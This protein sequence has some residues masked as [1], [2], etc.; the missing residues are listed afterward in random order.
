MGLD[1][2][3]VNDW[4]PTSKLM[5]GNNTVNVVKTFEAWTSFSSLNDYLKKGDIVDDEMVNYFTNVMPP[6]FHTS[7]IIQMGEP[8]NHVNGKA[9]Y[10][11]L[12]KTSKGWTYVGDCHRGK[13]HK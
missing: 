10:H 7:N 13:T 1:I 8:Y 9:T 3:I 2:Y 6:A 4:E 5:E 12:Q 11:T